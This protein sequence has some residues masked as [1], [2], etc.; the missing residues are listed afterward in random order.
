MTILNSILRACMSC[1]QAATSGLTKHNSAEGSKLNTAGLATQGST[2]SMQPT[3]K[4]EPGVKVE[5]VTHAVSSELLQSSSIGS[6]EEPAAALPM[7][8]DD[9]AMFQRKPPKAVKPEPSEVGH[10]MLSCPPT[11]SPLPLELV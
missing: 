2:D 5:G 10:C 1:L 4:A 11:S 8:V 7:E 6:K 9:D 3:P